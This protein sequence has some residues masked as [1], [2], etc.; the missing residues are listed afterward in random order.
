MMRNQKISDIFPVLSSFSTGLHIFA[1]TKKTVISD[2]HH[3][4]NLI[5]KWDKFIVRM[6]Q[7]KLSVSF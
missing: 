6:D 7:S 2:F 4:L 5:S 1:A 3:R